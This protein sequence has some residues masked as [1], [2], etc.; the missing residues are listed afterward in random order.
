[1]AEIAPSSSA[2]PPPVKNITSA[3]YGRDEELY[4][5]HAQDVTVKM[6]RNSA[7]NATLKN[8]F[9]LYIQRAE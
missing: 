4:L 1:M 5:M 6:N 3:W 7:D 2:L 9:E 8:N